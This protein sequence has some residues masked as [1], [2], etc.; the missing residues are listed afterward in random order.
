MIFVSA[1]KTKMDEVASL[2][3]KIYD[4][5]PKEYPNG[6]MMVFIPMHED[7]HFSPEYRKK[8]NFQS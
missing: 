3:H 6:A 2:F 8:N 4:G 7:T 5:T 1:E